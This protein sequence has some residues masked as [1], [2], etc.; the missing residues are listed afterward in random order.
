MRLTL[1]LNEIQIKLYHEVA[2]VWFPISFN[3][4]IILNK[5]NKKYILGDIK[6]KLFL[7]NCSR[8]YDNN[9]EKLR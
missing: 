8:N 6:K 2:F 1:F 5:S 7:L 4:I 9:Y 3:F